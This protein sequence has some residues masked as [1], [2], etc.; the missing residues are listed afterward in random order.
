MPQPP[1]RRQPPVR[2]QQQQQQRPVQPVAKPV[3]RP[4]PQIRPNPPCARCKNPVGTDGAIVATAA[5][6]S[7]K[8]P[9]IKACCKKCT[10]PADTIVP[11]TPCP[12]CKHPLRKNKCN[13]KH[14]ETC[15]AIPTACPNSAHGCNKRHRRG[16]AHEH[17]IGCIPTCNLC[18]SS[19][20]GPN[21]PCVANICDL[22]IAHLRLA[23]RDPS[24]GDAA[25]L[26]TLLHP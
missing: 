26:A 9:S 12:G 2:Q 25:I 7:K 4:A 20:A 18:Q 14:L 6:S 1:A 5:S 10:S 24:V 13:I 11:S 8:K 15:A 16:D 3:V 21:H 19:D 23:A 22:L 17:A